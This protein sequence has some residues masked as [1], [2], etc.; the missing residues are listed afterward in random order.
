[1]E[2]YI[3]IQSASHSADE[4]EALLTSDIGS[5][6]GV[7]LQVNRSRAVETAVLAAAVGVVGA[8]LG[9][10]IRGLL[11]VAA[12]KR[13]SKIVVQGRS[14]RKLEVPANTPVDEIAALIELTKE[15]DVDQ[16]ELI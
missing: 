1:M 14:G 2:H 11:N 9:A 10:L 13:A 8:G 3:S 6:A 15:I 16:I 5:D 7:R 4:L 12:Q